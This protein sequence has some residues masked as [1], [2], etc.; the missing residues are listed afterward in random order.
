MRKACATLLLLASISWP[1]RA[2]PQARV[3]AVQ[4]P[5][6]VERGARREPAAAGMAL[7]A[8][9]RIRT[10][11][12]A[13][14]YLRLADGST[15]KVGANGLLSLEDL[16]RARADRRVFTAVMD[17]LQG[18]FRFTT[19]RLAR[20]AKRDV[21]I[22]VATV[23]VGI[24][25]TDVWGRT[26]PEK[27]F[28]CL[29]DGRVTVAHESGDTREMSEPMTFYLAPRDQPPKGVAPVDPQQVRKWA[30]ETEITT[31]DGASRRG[32]R[33]KVRLATA[34]SRQ[35]ALDAYDRAREAGFAASIRPRTRAG[36]TTYEVL[37]RDLPDRAEARILAQK[38]KAALGLEAEPAL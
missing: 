34:S 38:L 28:V 5:A 21:K 6:W 36:V 27:D 14:I 15:V 1:A 29:L 25:G 8:G 9:E 2:A 12:D 18:A 33:W 22:R 32:G 7:S 23:T 37:L 19:G 26:E 24:R 31:G 11:K 16:G 17:V 35:E 4:A 20:R 10:G 13:R 3:D 30:A